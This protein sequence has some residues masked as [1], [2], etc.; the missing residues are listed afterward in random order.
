MTKKEQVSQSVVVM[1]L[2]SH[3]SV[4]VQGSIIVEVRSKT[5]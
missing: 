1:F 4:E 2:R 3:P 5:T